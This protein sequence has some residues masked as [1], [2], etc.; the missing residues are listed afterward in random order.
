MDQRAEKRPREEHAWTNDLCMICKAEPRPFRVLNPECTHGYCDACIHMSK[1][2]QC[3]Y[4]KR[5]HIMT[6]KTFTSP[7]G[8]I[9]IALFTYDGTLMYDKDVQVYPH[10]LSAVGTIGERMSIHTFTYDH[11][12]LAEWLKTNG[13]FYTRTSDKV[14]KYR[15][16]FGD[17][18]YS[19]EVNNVG[20]FF[21]YGKK[22]SVKGANAVLI[23]PVR[24]YKAYIKNNVV[25]SMEEDIPLYYVIHLLQ[26]ASD[27]IDKI[28]ST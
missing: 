15:A 6:V 20:H 4:C 5:L 10:Q 8:D 23:T 22:K 17:G 11:P 19:T 12:H 25:R 24:A 7:D 13:L 9:L 2:H 27:A 1:C 28:R 3:D 26:A 14:A 21:Y 16:R 18:V